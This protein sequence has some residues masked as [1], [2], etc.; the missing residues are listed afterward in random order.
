MGSWHGSC[1][2]V[3][4]DSRVYPNVN[5]LWITLWITHVLHPGNTFAHVPWARVNPYGFGIEPRGTIVT[6]VYPGA[7]VW[8]CSVVYA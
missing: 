8:G 5:I 2:G 7:G 4:G 3:D 1:M 6:R